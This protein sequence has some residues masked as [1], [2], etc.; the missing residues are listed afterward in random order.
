M[1]K[2]RARKPVKEVPVSAEEEVEGNDKKEGRTEENKVGLIDQEGIVVLES[3]FYMEQIFLNWYYS[4]GI[5][6][7]YHLFCFRA[8]FVDIE[9]K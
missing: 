8:P 4:L 6:A 5:C 3:H 7:F 9:S 2:R 1:A